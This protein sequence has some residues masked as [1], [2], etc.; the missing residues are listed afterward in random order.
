VRES[1]RGYAESV[2]EDSAT[3][4]EPG[5]IGRLLHP[6]AAGGG[7]L[8]T[9]AADVAG[10]RDL[11]D[12]SDELRSV[13]S[14]PAI[15][16][17]ARRAVFSDLLA[18]RISANALRLVLFTVDVGR[19]AELGEDIEWLAAR[20]AAARDGRH[21]SG[22]A[23][24]GHHAAVERLDGYATAVLESVDDD[25]GLS[26]IEDEL[27]RFERIVAG[28]GDLSEALTGR[29]LPADA[30]SG[31][32][33]DLLAGRASPASTRLAAYAA[34]IGRPRDYL[35]LLDA[36]V[37]RVAAESHRRIADVRAVV[38][39]TDEQTARLA[40]ALGRIVGQH[41]EV[42]VTVDPSVL[43]GFVATIGDTVVDG[44]VRHR[45]DLLK[46]RLA[47][48][49]ATPTDPGAQTSEGAQS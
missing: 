16:P 6:G 34:T 17:H 19:P 22:P 45:L 4:E 30:R 31:L 3:A 20:T 44:S 48:P 26:E 37:A 1:I 2:I 36:L 18:D 21:A 8:A 42:R 9:L 29:D 27:F 14:D 10:I 46:E 12:G 15:P 47:S 5:V 28:S 33:G 49:E 40:A 43:G 7:D 11:V 23:I 38:D 32:V 24:L 41:V 25:R 13:L 39:L 35:S